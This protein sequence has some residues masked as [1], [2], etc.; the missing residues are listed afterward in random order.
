MPFRLIS[1]GV[2][3]YAD[4][5]I[6]RLPPCDDD[7][8]S[9]SDT[10]TDSTYGL[11]LP[12]ESVTLRSGGDGGM[13]STRA[14][15]M[16][17]LKRLAFLSLPDD[18]L[19]FYFSGHGASQGGEGYLL[20]QD[21]YDNSLGDT[22][23]AIRWVTKTMSESQARYRVAILDCCKPGRLLGKQDSGGMDS[24]FESCLPP[25]A[26]LIILT[27]CSADQ[28][29]HLLPDESGSV[30]THFI[31][32]CL[33][34]SSADG[35]D[36]IPIKEL[37]EYAL[38]KCRDW[39]LKHNKQQ[40][41]RLATDGVGDVTGIGIAR[42]RRA[43]ISPPPPDETMGVVRTIILRST[44][45]FHYPR[46]IVERPA[47]PPS[48]NVISVYS[49][50]GPSVEYGDV[51]RDQVPG[52]KKS[53]QEQ[54][55]EILEA[56]AAALVDF[57][58]PNTLLRGTG[59]DFSFTNGRFEY[60]VVEEP[61]RCVV[62]VSFRL[63]VSMA[64]GAV[65]DRLQ[66]LRRWGTLSTVLVPEC[67]PTLSAVVSHA[68]GS[69]WSITRFSPERACEVEIQG[70]GKKSRAARIVFRSE[71]DGVL[72]QVSFDLETVSEQHTL[73]ALVA[74]VPKLLPPT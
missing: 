28:V 27:A 66:K 32:E 7:A 20:C 22:G 74:E 58:D 69:G 60:E 67:A 65:L 9:I 56:V 23:L 6:R 64:S 68:K 55:R 13:K 19:V 54:G 49:V 1:A 8:G 59:N 40:I 53:A 5:E 21:T 51:K 10:L 18:G 70:L 36:P 2:S 33:R 17:H 44:T 35:P 42:R 50:I 30:F 57:Y 45:A 52:L 37:Y 26:G 25:D 41:P 63:E 38:E 62:A 4:A 16:H 48:A 15:L 34:L 71:Q 46:E 31:L 11:C 73:S 47:L 3:D 61:L 29:S 43:P 72:E 12:T 14:N 39:S 24:V